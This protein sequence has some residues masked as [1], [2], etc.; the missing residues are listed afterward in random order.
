[1]LVPVAPGSRANR[2]DPPKRIV[3]GWQIAPEELAPILK[4]ERAKMADQKRH[5]PSTEDYLRAHTIGQLR[6][7]PAP[8]RLVHYDASWPG[9]FEHEAR[10]IRGALGDKAL[11]IEHVG[12]TSVPSLSA[13]PIIDILLVVADSADETDYGAALQRAGLRLHIREREWHEHRMFK[14]PEDDLHLDMFSAGCP[15]VERMLV[16]RDR[17]RTNEADRELYARCKQSLARPEGSTRR[18]TP[19]RKLR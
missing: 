1:V 13:K 3:S 17:L 19:R 2:N 6:A 12:S 10:K 9:R 8:I 16:F 7:H 15:E 4:G 5:P 18:I 11:R 14:G